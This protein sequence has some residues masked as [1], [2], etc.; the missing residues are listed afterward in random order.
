MANLRTNFWFVVLSC[1]CRFIFATTFIVTGLLKSNDPYG[2]GL[3]IESYFAAYD[4]FVPD[5]LVVGLAIGIGAAELTLGLMLI[6]NIYIRIASILAVVS[7]A[8]FSI[9]TLL[10]ATAFPVEDCGCFGE[11]IKLSP[12]QSFAKNMVLLP[13]AACFWYHYRPEKFFEAWKRDTL[14]TVILFAAAVTLNIY[15]YR[16]LPIVDTS[17]YREGVD[18]SAEM[19]RERENKDSERAVLVYRN[20]QTGELHEFA[21]DDK[22]WQDETSWEWVETR[23]ENE[24]S[25]TSTLHDFY[26]CDYE[27]NDKT[28]Y[29]LS[30]P[31]VYM[32]FVV[33]AEYAEDITKQF[34][35]VERYADVNGGEVVYVSPVQLADLNNKYTYYNMDPKTMQTILRA[36]YGLVVLENGVVAEKYNYRDIPY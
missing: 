14:V 18:I 16:H 9:I 30:L 35:V 31:K 15:S 22:T 10:S 3:V 26:V 8:L 24:V 23:V 25:V 20:I 1:T 19:E 11:V 32:L 2:T 33:N 36:E 27:G 34:E 4:I 21:I 28:E 13:M 5:W 7:M 17:L 29:L 12:W 6:F